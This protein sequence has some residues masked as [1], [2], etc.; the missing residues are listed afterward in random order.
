[1]EFGLNRQS[2][3]T[4]RPSPANMGLELPGEIR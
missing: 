4:S 3:N 2:R 1:M